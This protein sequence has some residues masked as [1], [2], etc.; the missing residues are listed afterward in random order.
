M[1][2]DLHYASDRDRP[3]HDV[4]VISGGQGYVVEP[5]ARALVKTLEAAIQSVHVRAGGQLVIL[6]RQ[7]IAFEAI[8]KSG[9]LWHTRRLSW[10]GFRKVTFVDDEL[11]G[12]G[13]NAIDQQWQSFKVDLRTGRSVGGAYE[14]RDADEWERLGAASGDAS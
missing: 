14:W 13:W 1:D 9:W 2:N 11:T 10:D 5:D 12:E 4:L 6:D 3:G 8:G 7:G